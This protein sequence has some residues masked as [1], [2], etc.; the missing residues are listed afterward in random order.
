MA[1]LD[2][3]MFE[4]Q[5]SCPGVNTLNW[6]PLPNPVFCN[7]FEFPATKSNIFHTLG[8]KTMKKILL[9]L[10]QPG[11]SNNTKIAPKF[12]YSSWFQIYIIFSEKVVQ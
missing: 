5:L 4:I 7:L 2:Y 8:L 6:F 10:T 12:Q 9:N 3:P 1:D 11:L